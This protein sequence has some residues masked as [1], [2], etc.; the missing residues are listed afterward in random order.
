MSIRYALRPLTWLVLL[1]AVGG[2]GCNTADP[3]AGEE[4][5]ATMLKKPDITAKTAAISGS[6]SATKSGGDLEP[7]TDE[8]G[9]LE[10]VADKIEIPE[11]VSPPVDPEPT[12]P[13]KAQP[14]KRTASPPETIPAVSGAAKRFFEEGKQ[15][16]IARQYARA[17]ASYDKAL[18]AKPDFA[19]A[20]LYKGFA[21]HNL[22]RNDEA[23][24]AFEEAAQMG[25]ESA[26][27]TFEFMVKEGY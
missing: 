3:G 27:R 18:D 20:L 13:A 14:T 2:E 11:E 22:N 15:F 21:L 17:I 8:S 12:P 1:I 6:P 5:E 7:V 25:D 24:T 26:R 10:P 16:G 9:D 19:K 23:M 4:I